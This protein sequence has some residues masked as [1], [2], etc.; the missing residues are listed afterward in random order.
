MGNRP[1][2][3]DLPGSHPGP[4]GLDRTLRPCRL[5]W[6][7]GHPSGEHRPGQHLE[8]EIEVGVG[9]QLAAL[10][11]GRQQRS[12]VAHARLDDPLPVEGQGAGVPARS[13]EGAHHLQTAL[14]EP[15]VEFGQIE[16]EIATAD[17]LSRVHLVQERIDLEAE[18]ASKQDT[19]DLEALE[20][21][22][23][24]A[25]R[26]YG[27]RKGITYKAWREAGVEASVLARAGIPRTRG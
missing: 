16:D 1:V 4:D 2:G 19:V 9:V 21:G 14:G 26:G 8:R 22:F 23:V 3:T 10:D 17:P 6:L 18:L 7:A 13:D 27:E 5:R 15:F 24:K 12:Q 20:D 25:A 11:S